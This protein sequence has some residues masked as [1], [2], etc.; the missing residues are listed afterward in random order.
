MKPNQ[1]ITL[2]LAIVAGW[3]L[4]AGADEESKEFLPVR[5]VFENRFALI[6]TVGQVIERSGKLN[7]KWS[8]HAWT[9]M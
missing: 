5:I 9:I 4:A 3:N 7:T 1:L 6:A 2:G 8:S